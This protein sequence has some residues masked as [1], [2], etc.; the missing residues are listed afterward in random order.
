MRIAID[1]LA[2]N[3]DDF[4]G[5]EQYLA[6]LVS[7]LSD[8]DKQNQYYIFVCPQNKEK[9]DLTRPNI[10]MIECA[11]DNR[12]KIRRILFEQFC[13]PR[14]LK[15]YQIDIYHGPNNTLPL[16]LPCPAVV[17][18][19]FM[20]NFISPTQFKPFYKRWY[21]NLLMKRSVRKADTVIAVSESLAKEINGLLGVDF[22][23]IRVVHHG[24]SSQFCQRKEPGEADKLRHDF[25]ITR[26]YILCVANNVSNKNYCGLI[27]A[28]AKLKSA[29]QIPHQLIFVGSTD[30]DPVEKA[31]TLNVIAALPQSISAD[32]LF[33]GFIKHGEL[34]SLYRG[35]AV[36]ALPSFCESFGIPLV[37]AMAC[38]AP[39]VTS[40]VSVMPEIIRNAG[41]KVD[42]KNPSAI[43]EAIYSIISNET[44]RRRLSD[45]AVHRAQSFTWQNAAEKTLSVYSEIFATAI[46]TEPQKKQRG[47][48][49][50]NPPRE[51]PQ[52]VD[53]PPLGLAYLAAYL[54]QN[55][56]KASVLDAAGMTWK[57]LVAA[58]K[59]RQPYIVGLPCWTVEREQTFMAAKLVKSFIPDVK[60]IFG[61]HH[62]TVF[63][64]QM[65]RLADADAVVLGEG[66]LTTLELVTSLLDNA[67]LAGIKGI[68]Y[69]E[70]GNI[71]ITEPREFISDL[72]TIP[73][74]SYDDFN[75]DDY[76]G[77]PE[78]TR[79]SAALM[80]SRGCPYACVYCAAS[81][82]WKRQWRARS[83]Q[84]VL[85][86]IDYLYRTHGVRA[87]MFFDDNFTIRK[88]RVIDICHGII[89][90][91][92]DVIWAACSHVNQIDA[93]ML[94]WM[95]KAGCYRIDFGV[96]SGSPEVLKNIKKNQT[97]AKVEETFRLCHE[98]GIKPRA[99]LMVGN[100]GEN[101]KTIDETIALLTKIKPHDTISGQILW[102]LPGTEIY[103]IA[104]AKGIISDDYWLKNDKF[105]PYYTGEHTE[106]ELKKLRDKLTHGTTKIDK[107]FTAYLSYLIRKIYYRFPVLQK[108]RALKKR[109]KI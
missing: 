21:F 1:T 61:G 49:F 94:D 3:R 90:R 96:E 71:V 103:D 11:V 97:T 27:H 85:A 41:L 92:L 39:I 87:L 50:I 74:P 73:F 82:F 81:K 98:A 64:A 54:K 101:D 42:P 9:F 95:K 48:L 33:L 20:I 45:R 4:G 26:P 89:E 106:K 72:D 17:T 43:A 66:E 108:A 31:K 35:A 60:L 105:I 28:F 13:L 68:A 16:W 65:F 100:P 52:R 55:N 76:L 51:V 5:G 77:L 78:T 53:Y 22:K 2:V 67:P 75:L 37:E 38:G 25:N 83:A 40:N 36:F 104:K 93:E 47:V 44:L 18:I 8:I 34:P 79:K 59:K 107:K 14:L 86:E 10:K 84:N 102:I 15:A 19:Q 32:I 62:A 46:S 88:D 7:A 63:P 109:F 69:R 99:Y 70:A 12:Y 30:I 58:V 56:I 91:Q 80:T 24:V 23:K 29:H 57:Q 6:N